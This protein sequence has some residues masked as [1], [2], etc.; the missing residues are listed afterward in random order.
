MANR[1]VT[2]AAAEWEAEEEEAEE[3]ETAFDN[4][5]EGKETTSLD[6]L[7]VALGNVEPLWGVGDRR[8]KNMRQ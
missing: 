3:A 6:E 7:N 1:E 8:R 5:S 2:A 4:E